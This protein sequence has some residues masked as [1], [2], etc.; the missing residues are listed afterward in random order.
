[1]SLPQLNSTSP[2]VKAA[3][4]EKVYDKY[5]MTRFLVRAPTPTEPVE[6]VAVFKPARD[7]TVGD[8]TYK[9]LNPDAKE[10]KIRIEDLFVAA[11]EDPELTV[12]MSDLLAKLKSI[13]VDQGIFE[14]D[15]SS[16]SSGD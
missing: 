1:M 2:N 8:V 10:V 6:I 14:V 12:V 5:W 15:N 11:E 3:T 9:E 16:S 7:V 4:E 13:G